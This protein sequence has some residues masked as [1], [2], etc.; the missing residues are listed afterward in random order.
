MTEQL[1]FCGLEAMRDSAQYTLNLSQRLAWPGAT[2]QY[3]GFTPTSKRRKQI[4]KLMRWVMGTRKVVVQHVEYKVMTDPWE[5]RIDT[6]GAFTE[7]RSR[8]VAPLGS[9]KR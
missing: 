5:N 9:G 2:L 3:E 6:A 4:S 1:A 7:G 8:G